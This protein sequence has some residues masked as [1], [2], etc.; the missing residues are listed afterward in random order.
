MSPLCPSC[1]SPPLLLVWMNVSSLTPWLLDFPYSSIFCQ[2]WLLFV[3]KFVVALLLVVRG[4][5]VYLPM[6]PSW[7]GESV[8]SI[9]F[10]QQIFIQ[11]P[12][13]VSQCKQWR[14]FKYCWNAGRGMV[15]VDWSEMVLVWVGFLEEVRSDPNFL[16]VA[17]RGGWIVNFTVWPRACEKAKMRWPE[18]MLD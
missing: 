9:G 4:G 1:P 12:V 18:G 11:W 14:E 2:F 15:R 17:G 10:T 7:P 6:P 16:A 5:K 13:H 8:E 3:F